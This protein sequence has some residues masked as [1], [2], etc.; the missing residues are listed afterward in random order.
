MP[1]SPGVSSSPP[2]RP[3]HPDLKAPAR[4]PPDLERD[5]Y[6]LAFFELKRNRNL[7]ALPERP[8][9]WRAITARRPLAGNALVL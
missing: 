6:L 8:D 9:R 1:E 3:S 4:Q 2:A 5:T 7:F